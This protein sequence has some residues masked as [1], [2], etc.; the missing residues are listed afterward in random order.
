MSKVVKQRA[1]AIPYMLNEDGEI[2]MMF[3]KPSDPEFGGPDFQIAKGEIE[4]GELT[5][6]AGFR[7]AEEEL[8]LYMNNVIAKEE[9]GKFIGSMTVYVAEVAD[10]DMFGAPSY[11]TGETTWMTLEE[12][13]A[14]GRDLHR[15]AVQ[16]AY[17]TIEKMERL[18]AKAN[19]EE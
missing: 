15:P 9:V 17:R 18:K 2:I 5:E 4:R 10:K 7:E 6:D 12:Y 8:G 3:M 1:G 19:E 13:K 16:A 11:E 14:T